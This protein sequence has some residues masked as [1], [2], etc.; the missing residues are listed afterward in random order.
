MATVAVLGT[1][2]LG[3]GMVENLLA[4]GHAVRAWNRSRDKLAPLAAKGAIA[5]ADP[6]AAVRGAERVHLVLAADD[7]VDEVLAAARPGL[8]AGVPVI[9]HSTNLPARVAERFARLR[10][11]KVRYVPAP[12]FMGP[13]NAR[14]GSGLMLLAGPK[15]DADALEPALLQMT[16]KVLYAGERPDQAAVFKLAGNAVY[17]AMTA[18]MGDVLA[19]GKA[20]GVPA[21]ALLALFDVWKV[22][23]ALPGI[24]RRV[25]SADTGAPSF[26]LSM[27]RKDARLMIET[28]GPDARL[29]VLPAIATAMDRA[30]YLGNAHAD[31]AVFAKPS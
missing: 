8:A 20:A 4:K 15:P 26:E 13:Q 2:L 31:Y 21:D 28:A 23:G 9:D 22:G 12:V 17:F 29:T 3:G 18:V 19:M 5:A 25:A 16:A 7:A 24:G 6:A 11:E 14:E 1:G 27:A 10:A 30:L